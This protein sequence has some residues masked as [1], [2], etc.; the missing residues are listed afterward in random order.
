MH[1]I[2]LMEQRWHNPTTDQKRGSHTHQLKCTGVRQTYGRTYSP[3]SELPILYGRTRRPKLVITIYART[4]HR[5]VPVPFPLRAHASTCQ[6]TSDLGHIVCCVCVSRARAAH[7]FATCS[8]WSCAPY[9]LRGR[10]THAHLPR[11]PFATD[12]RVHIPNR[13]P[14]PS[15]VCGRYARAIEQVN[16]IVWTF[17]THRLGIYQSAVTRYMPCSVI[18]YCTANARGRRCDLNYAWR[19]FETYPVCILHVRNFRH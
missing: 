11:A 18:V 1:A 12:A 17:Y 9:M 6:H 7:T 2:S 14:K 19:L 15:H 5:S 4:A 3:C 13:Y 16:S 8:R 10:R